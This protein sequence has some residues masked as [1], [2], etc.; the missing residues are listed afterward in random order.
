MST[1]DFFQ[2]W[3]GNGFIKN[4]WSYHKGQSYKYVKQSPANKPFARWCGRHKRIGAT[5]DVVRK[6]FDPRPFK[7][8]LKFKSSSSIPYDF[9]MNWTTFHF[10]FG[11]KRNKFYY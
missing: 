3:I 11:Q 7:V 2:S 8:F 1:Y 9:K 6:Q 4:W 5:S 10:R